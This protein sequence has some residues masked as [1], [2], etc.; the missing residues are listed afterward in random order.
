MFKGA[1]YGKL[2]IS[3]MFLCELRGVSLGLFEYH[4]LTLTDSEPWISR[5]QESHLTSVI[6]MHKQRPA[7]TFV[8]VNR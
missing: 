5:N 1:V 7:Q 4:A 3:R 8:S 2:A 6:V